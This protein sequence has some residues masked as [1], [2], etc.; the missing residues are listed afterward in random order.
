ML[1]EQRPDIFA[2]MKKRFPFLLFFMLS[3]ISFGQKRERLLYKSQECFD[4]K[5][6]LCAKE[7]LRKAYNMDSTDQFVLNNL[8]VVYQNLNE[9]DTALIFYNKVLD[10]VPDDVF[11]L[12]NKATILANKKDYEGALYL[13]NIANQKSSFN[14]TT[15]LLR[16]RVYNHL[17]NAGAAFAD[18]KSILQVNPKHRGARQ[19]LAILKFENKDL[20][21]A[22]GDFIALLIDHPKD[23]ISLYTLAEIELQNLNLKDALSYSN[24]AIEVNPKHIKAYITRGQIE[25]KLDQ[26]ELACKDFMVAKNLAAATE[27]ECLSGFIEECDK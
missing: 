17:K 20:E 7:A 14:E 23:I 4:E 21:G 18:L 10:Q 26:R 19:N 24:R 27:M 5:D 12:N 11:A 16:S 22:K 13:L 2:N 8:G 9:P 25:L 3:I 1:N 15:L 6:F